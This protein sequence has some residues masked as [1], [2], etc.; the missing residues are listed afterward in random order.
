MPLG[1]FVYRIFVVNRPGANEIF[2]A[3]ESGM[4]VELCGV[5]LAA[6]RLFQ[7]ESRAPH[8]A[9]AQAFR[10]PPPQNLKW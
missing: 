2:S 1:R 6:L 9:V 5:H 8:R 10:L 4:L 3:F 7:A